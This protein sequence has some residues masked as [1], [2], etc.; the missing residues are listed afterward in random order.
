VYETVLFVRVT[1]EC[2]V[3][4]TPKEGGYAYPTIVCACMPGDNVFFITDAIRALDITGLEVIVGNDG[5]DLTPVQMLWLGHPFELDMPNGIADPGIT[6]KRVKLGT[7]ARPR[8]RLGATIQHSAVAES[9]FD[10]FIERLNDAAVNHE[11][12][13]AVVWPAGAQAECGIVRYTGDELEVDDERDF[14][15][16]DST[17]RLLR[18][19]LPLEPVA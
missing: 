1:D 6:K 14:Q 12:R 9:A 3:S 11:G 7:P 5:G 16:T 13:F 19:S 15:P 17:D 18:F 2:T 10:D 8:A 4:V